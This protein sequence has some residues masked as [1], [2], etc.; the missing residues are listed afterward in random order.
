[1]GGSVSNSTV[2]AGAGAD[3]MSVDGAMIAGEFYG[4]S[5][6]DSVL[7]GGS[8]GGVIEL[9]DGADSLV[10]TAANAA[11]V[12]GGTENDT[13]SLPVQCAIP[14][15]WVDSV[16]TASPLLVSCVVRR[17]GAVTRQMVVAPSMVLITS[18][19][20]LLLRRPFTATVV[21]TACSLAVTRQPHR[22]T[23]VWTMIW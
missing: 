12:L 16:W 23:A 17:F 7:L 11:T 4:G 20:P 19:W 6:A 15:W 13:F 8:L 5:G 2:Y 9:S 1:M 18:V 14:A 21:P 22:F 10:A 3:F